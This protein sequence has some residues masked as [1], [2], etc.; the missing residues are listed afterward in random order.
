LVFQGAGHVSSGLEF[1]NAVL[2]K[3]A[4]N[5]SRL[6]P[7]QAQRIVELAASVQ[8]QTSVAALMSALRF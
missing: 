3:W 8:Q 6:P 7:E 4:L 5:A 2:E 1:R